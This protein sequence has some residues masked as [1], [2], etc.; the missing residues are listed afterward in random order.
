MRHNMINMLDSTVLNHFEE[1]KKAVGTDK[2]RAL[3]AA[4]VYGDEITLQC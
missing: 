3:Q 2:K 4:H 1:N